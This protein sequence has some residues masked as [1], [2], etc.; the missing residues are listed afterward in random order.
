LAGDV[1]TARQR[2]AEHRDQGRARAR[3]AGD[4]QARASG[5]DAKIDGLMDHAESLIAAFG[6]L[7]DEINTSGIATTLPGGY[8]VTAEHAAATIL[9][10]VLLHCFP[11]HLVADVRFVQ[12]GHERP[13]ADPDA[14]HEMP[15]RM[16][17]MASAIKEGRLPPSAPAPIGQPEAPIAVE[18][19]ERDVI[20]REPISYRGTDHRLVLVAGGPVRLPAPIVAAALERGVGHKPGSPAAEAILRDLARDGTS[21]WLSRTASSISAVDLSE[22]V[23]QERGRLADRA[24]A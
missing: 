5:I 10:N 1:A 3:R 2:L 13:V 14:L 22:H 11:Q 8:S 24:A 4:L 18:I 12:P 19:D 15:I 9:G 6:E 7:R 20:L 21:Y 23:A 17:S 16:R